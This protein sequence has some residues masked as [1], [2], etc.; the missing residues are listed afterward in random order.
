MALLCGGNSVCCCQR[1]ASASF[2][3]HLLRD[4]RGEAENTA[5]QLEDEVMKSLHRYISSHANLVHFAV[6]QPHIKLSPR[7]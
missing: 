5:G 1:G 3:G 7:F 4:Y 2:L 6:K